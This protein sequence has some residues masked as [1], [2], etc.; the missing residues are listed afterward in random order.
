[1]IN[2]IARLILVTVLG[3]FAALLAISC[4]TLI[5]MKNIIDDKLFKLGKE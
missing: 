1:M 5:P 2:L 3:F 4:L